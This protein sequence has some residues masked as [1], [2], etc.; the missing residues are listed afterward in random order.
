MAIVSKTN[1]DGVDIVIEQLQQKTYP[2]LLGAW[3]GGIT[4]ESYPRANKN[5]KKEQVLPQLSLDELDYKEVL[6]DDKKSITSFFVV[7]DTRVFNDVTKQ[8]K[9]TIHMIFQADL[10]QLYGNTERLDEVFNMDVHRVIKKES[11][12]IVGDITITEGIDNVYSDFTFD[13]EMQ[14]KIDLHDMSKFHVLKVTFDVLYKDDCAKTFAPVCDPVSIF[15]NGIQIAS[16]PSGGSYSYSTSVGAT[17]FTSLTGQENTSA[18]YDDGWQFQNG[19]YSN[20]ILSD[21]HTLVN[22]NEWGHNKRFTGDTGGYMDFSTGIF[23]DVNHNVTT[24]ALAFPND[25]LRDY[26]YRRR[27]YLNRSGART[28]ANCISLSPTESKGGETGWRTPSKAEYEQISSNN[29]NSPTYIDNRL[30]NWSLFNMWSSTEALNNSA[31]AHRYSAG[32][33]SW[34]IQSKTILAANAYIKNF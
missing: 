31:N 19:T 14:K 5:N 6:M 12:Y 13:P 2:L 27:W 9:Q 23:Y 8:Y 22:A 34:S 7:D 17:Y 25:I 20:A 3:T 29:A 21:Y 18:L 28:W 16:I 1:R 33:D 4:Y 32:S 15:E 26:A 10:V 30:F 11:V 24:K